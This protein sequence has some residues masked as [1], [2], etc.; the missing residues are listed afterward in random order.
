ML[1][2]IDHLV[3]AVADPDAA[4]AELEAE[5]G[6]AATGGG[7][8]DAG[9]HN[10]LVFLGDAY[11]ELIGVWDRARALAH[12][13]GAAVVRALDAGLPGLV[14]YAVA[15]D[16]ARRE[17]MALRATG[18]AVS[19]VVGGARVRPDGETVA[20]HCAFPPLLGPAEPPFLI[21]HELNGAE[22]GVEAR[23]ARASFVHPFGGTAR[24]VGIEIV[25]PDPAATAAAYAA[26]IGV[27]VP[28]G[29]GPV[30]GER[31]VRIGGQ[32]V[33]LVPPGAGPAGVGISAARGRATRDAAARDSATRDAAA[34]D[35]AA[36]EP[37]ARVGILATAGG[38]VLRD[39]FGV[40]FARRDLFGV[41]FAR[42]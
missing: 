14:T 35:A 20:W 25:V 41:R 37:A 10:R 9:T 30:P 1:L 22:W 2:G 38:R 27:A 39:L 26:V 18:S 28:P 4:A 13:I 34:R 5:L 17:V 21:E 40:R 7:R 24:L 12:P 11:L 3:I 42:L 33:R 8:H 31:E 32:S 6:L 36:A 29:P 23:R 16:G 19:D 15:T